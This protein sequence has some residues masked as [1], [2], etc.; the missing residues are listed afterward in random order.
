MQVSLNQNLQ[1]PSFGYFK[2]S[3]E[4][5]DYIIK[6][7]KPKQLDRFKKILNAEKNNSVVEASI[8]YNDGLMG[9][10][11]I[12]DKENGLSIIDFYRDLGYQ[13]FFSKLF[14]G[15]LGYLE[16]VSKA[17]SKMYEKYNQTQKVDS[18]IKDVNNII[19]NAT[20]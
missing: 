12:F 15:T 9:S 16:D 10:L 2:F 7:I 6:T 5:H 17:S 4:A 1:N 19:E 11:R 3:N 18:F 8:Q 13:G 20:K 14:K